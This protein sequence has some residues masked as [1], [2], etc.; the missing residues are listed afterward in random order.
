MRNKSSCVS[1]YLLSFYPSSAALT[2]FKKIREKNVFLTRS[3][4][5]ARLL[6]KKPFESV[7]YFVLVEVY[8]IISGSLLNAQA[9]TDPGPRVQ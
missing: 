1:F 7:L 3:P 9:C 8:L 4:K 5:S 2:S 6:C